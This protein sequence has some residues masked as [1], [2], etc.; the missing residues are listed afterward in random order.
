VAVTGMTTTTSGTLTCSLCLS[1]V[2]ENTT[3][4]TSYGTVYD[5]PNCGHV[6]IQ[7]TAVEEKKERKL[8]KAESW[9]ERDKREKKLFNMRKK[10]H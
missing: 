9:F 7:S 8:E 1:P 2:R 4:Y 5:C 10:C 6:T 3:T